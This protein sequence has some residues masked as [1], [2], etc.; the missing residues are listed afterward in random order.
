MDSHSQAVML[1]PC[2]TW[3]DVCRHADGM[4]AVFLLSCVAA[5]ISLHYMTGIV[6]HDAVSNAL[7]HGFRQATHQSHRA[8][9]CNAH[10]QC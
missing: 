1:A 6:D 5:H 10:M 9:A 2:Q 7:C 4:L 8:L 3:L